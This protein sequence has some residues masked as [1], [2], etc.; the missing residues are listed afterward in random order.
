MA[1]HIELCKD[2]ACE[3]VQDKTIAVQHVA[4]KINPANIFTKEMRNSA[5][6]R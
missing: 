5:H 3:W 1:H 2:S 4:G 6:F